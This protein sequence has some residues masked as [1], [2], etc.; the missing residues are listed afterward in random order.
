MIGTGSIIALFVIASTGA[1]FA[2][3]VY[4][5][6]HNLTLRDA[7]STFTLQ[8][9]AI[10]EHFDDFFV[11]RQRAVR[12]IADALNTSTT[13]GSSP[14]DAAAFARVCALLRAV[15]YCFSNAHHRD[16]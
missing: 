9:A 6:V 1:S 14:V 3:V 11:N 8:F 13:D 15:L 2:T 7:R 12:G 16:A 5:N 4:V 10:A